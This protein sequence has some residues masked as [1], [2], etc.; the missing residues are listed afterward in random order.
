MTRK[1]AEKLRRLQNKGAREFSH[2]ARYLYKVMRLNPAA[3]PYFDNP[4]TW[5]FDE[6]E[7][8]VED[9]T[10]SLA[11]M[12]FAPKSI[13]ETR[14]MF[15]EIH[16]RAQLRELIGGAFTPLRNHRSK[17]PVASNRGV[18]LIHSKTFISTE[19]ARKRIPLKLRF[20]FEDGSPKYEATV[21]LG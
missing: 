3:C 2:N 21:R 18:Y 13:M 12:N 16:S 9:G 15:R 10:S 14:G 20:E 8:V 1:K 4:T 6:N 19:E 11:T 5:K 17:R 7:Q